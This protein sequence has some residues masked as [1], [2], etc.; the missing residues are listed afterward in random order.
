MG[1]AIEKRARLCE[2]QGNKMTSAMMEVDGQENAAPVMNDGGAARAKKNADGTDARKNQM[3]VEKYRPSRLADVAAHK[4]IIDT[5]GRLTKEDK[6]PHLLLYG[7]PGTGKTS[8]ILAVAKELY[9]PAFAQMTL[10]LNASDG[11]SIARDPAPP[12]LV[13]FKKAGEPERRLGPATRSTPRSLFS[14]LDRI[15]SHLAAAAV[16]PSSSS[17]T[18]AS[19]SCGTRSNPSRPRCASTRPGSSS[20]SSTSATA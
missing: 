16:F 18:A 7:P 8:T 1:T 19:T 13:F 10:E 14:N 2:L 15:S 6:L 5:I 17:Q 4:D 3:W 12:A 20:S 9:G 11:A